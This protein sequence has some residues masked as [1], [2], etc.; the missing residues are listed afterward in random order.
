MRDQAAINAKISASNKGR[1]NWSKGKELSLRIER[2]Y[3]CGGCSTQLQ[4]R[5]SEVSW[6]KR[7]KTCSPECRLK[8]ASLSGLKSVHSQKELRRSKNEAYFF[9]LCSKQFT[10]V[11]SNKPM[12]GGWDADVILT[13]QRIA[14]LWNGKWHYEKIT[15]QHSVL[16]VQNRD[17]LKIEAIKKGGFEPYVIKDMGKF[18]KIFVEE[19]FSDLVNW[20]SHGPHKAK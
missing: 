17:A 16:Q 14:V 9:D 12:F 2:S 10:G 19:Q 11:L 20:L 18:N 6:K 4:G 15:K 1:P 7:R 8:V 3:S 13:E 5:F